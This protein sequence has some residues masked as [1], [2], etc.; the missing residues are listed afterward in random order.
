MTPAQE[1]TAES[2]VLRVQ[3]L[4]GQRGAGTVEHEPR[5]MPTRGKRLGA[6][7]SESYLVAFA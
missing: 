7:S 4:A 2:L 1:V 6:H 5:R 3:K